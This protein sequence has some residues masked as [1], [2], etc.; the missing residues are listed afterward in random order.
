[1]PTRSCRYYS[2]I[3]S[4]LKLIADALTRPSVI[5]EDGQAYVRVV[6]AH[7]GTYSAPSMRARL[8]PRAC[9]F[10]SL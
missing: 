3:R 9:V 1:M 5:K 6:V 7:A 10:L 8:A 4:S 2:D